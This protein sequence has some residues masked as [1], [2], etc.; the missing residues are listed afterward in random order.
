MRRAARR[1]L[2]FDGRRRTRPAFIGFAL[3]LAFTCSCRPSFD[4][5]TDPPPDER[6]WCEGDALKCG[7][8]AA[9]GELEAKSDISRSKHGYMW[10]GELPTTE[11]A[12]EF[13]RRFQ[14]KLEFVGCDEGSWDA[15][16]ATS[17]N[18]AIERHLG[19]DHKSLPYGLGR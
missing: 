1:M 18:R 6:K 17:Y 13:E 5:S 14:V 8:P 19:I 12:E 15:R 7:D 11:V 4:A 2:A 16:K 10:I 9:R 3:A